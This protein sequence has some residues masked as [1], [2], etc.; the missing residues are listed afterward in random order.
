MGF[1]CFKLWVNG[2]SSVEEAEEVSWEGYNEGRFS[3]PPRF[4]FKNVFLTLC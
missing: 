1:L 3:S 4:V 2:H